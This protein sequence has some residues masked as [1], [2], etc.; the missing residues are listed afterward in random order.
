MRAFFANKLYLLICLA[1]ILLGLLPD[2]RGYEGKQSLYLPVA[3]S[4]LIIVFSFIDKVLSRRS[5]RDILEPDFLFVLAFA[6]FH[7]AYIWLFM[8]D[9]AEY[10]KEV[11]WVESLVPTAIYYCDLCLI[12]FLFGY[13]KSIGAPVNLAPGNSRAMCQKLLGVGRVIVVVALFFFWLPLLDAGLS[14]VFSDYKVLMGIGVLTVFGRLFW[15]GQYLAVAGV[16]IYCIASGFLHGKAMYGLFK[17]VVLAYIVQFLLIGDRGMFVALAIIPFLAYNLFQKRISVRILVA[18]TVGFLMVS[19]V[20]S[21]TR[22]EAIFDPVKMVDIYSARAKSLP[23]VDSLIEF[24]L[25][26]KT[27][28]IAMALVPEQY[29]YWHGRSYLYALSLAVPNLLD[30]SRE[31]ANSPGAWITEIAFGSLSETYGRGGSIAMESYLNF[32]FFAGSALFT[33]FGFVLKRVYL[34][35]IGKRTML[36]AVAYF[37][38]ISSLVLWMRNTSAVVPRTVLWALLIVYVVKRIKFG[39]RRFSAQQQARLP[40]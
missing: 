4:L 5:A 27:V 3:G 10:D 40:G 6:V 23:A 21:Q 30:I 14:R 12:M 33:V 36:W 26:L 16:S 7:F 2:T 15:F 28:V 19:S 34:S 8:L 13:G 38:L 1:V 32:G 17:F 18:A 25:S 37:S 9:I 39:S 29:A 31:S 11:F 35:F 22:T 24:G 20:V